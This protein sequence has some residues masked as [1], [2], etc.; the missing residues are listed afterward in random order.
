MTKKLAGRSFEYTYTSG[1]TGRVTF[2]EDQV[3]WE[4]VAGQGKGESGTDNYLARVVAIGIYFI[5]W[6]E[7][8]SQVTVTLLINEQTGK[9]YGSV[10]TPNDLGFDE[11][12]IHRSNQ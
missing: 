1:I 12:D 11:A 9:V 6:N 2:T 4:I 8:D 7:P 3:H 10:V 5:Q